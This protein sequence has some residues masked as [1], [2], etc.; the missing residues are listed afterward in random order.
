MIEAAGKN[1]R[2]IL[3]HHSEVIIGDEASGSFR[4]HV[5]V[6]K[7]GEEAYSAFGIPTV[8]NITPTF[9]GNRVTWRDDLAKVEARFYD[10]APGPTREHG[11]WEFELVLLDRP[12]SPSWVF[13]IE[14]KGLDWW[15][16]GPLSPVES[17]RGNVR[18][19]RVIGSYAVY[20]S[21][22]GVMLP[23]TEA[24]KYRTGKAF[25]FYRPVAVDALGNRKPLDLVYDPDLS[26]LTI[27]G[28]PAWFLAANY[29]VTID[30]DIGFT[31]LGGTPDST[32]NYILTTRFTAP[33]AGDANPGTWFF[34]SNGDSG[35][36]V[37]CA[38][39]SSAGDASPSGNSKVSSG[40]ALIT[41]GSTA[42]FYS[43]SVTW[44]SIAASTDY[45]LACNN[46]NNGRTYYDT[47][48]G[49]DAYFVART[50]ANDMPDPF[51]AGATDWGS[52]KISTYVSYTAGGAAG[53]PTMNR[54]GGIRELAKTGRGTW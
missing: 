52:Q 9:D 40:A 47:T 16:Q 35:V 36:V 6:K 50:H 30:P 18:P 12:A 37:A 22:K 28:D 43:A 25:H 20:H 8:R 41:L 10:L 48:G 7:W 32:N 53:Q 26:T 5:R 29:P 19:A 54:W 42:Q 39:Y 14:S 33:S 49:I 45:W 51:T 15:Y 1:F 2:G 23:S 11:G 3:A 4:P 38:A 21:S 17:A 24:D 34:G 13:P 31:S 46:A 27:S 44:T